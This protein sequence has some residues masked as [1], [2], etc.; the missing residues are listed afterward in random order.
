MA[1]EAHCEFADLDR[2]RLRHLGTL[3]LNF[4]SFFDIGAS[5]GGWS[6]TMSKEFPKAKFEMFEPL[7]DYLPEYKESTKWLLEENPRLRLHKFAVG[8][9]SR[10]IT[11]QV[12]EN[13]YASTALEGSNPPNA[14]P[15]DVSMITIDDAIASLGLRGPAIPDP[16]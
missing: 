8:A 9:S 4:E 12:M 2:A 13:P 5:N 11:M 6:A 7:T 1:L 15:V 16:F 14:R 10:R 3:G